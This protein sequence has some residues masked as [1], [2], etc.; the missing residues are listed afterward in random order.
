[1]TIKIIAIAIVT[2]FFTVLVHAQDTAEKEKLSCLFERPFIFGASISA[3]YGTL[4][5]GVNAI[6]TLKANEYISS[7]FAAKPLGSNPD[8]VTRLARTY[9]PNPQIT[10]ISEIINIMEHSSIGA[11]QFIS[12]ANDSAKEPNLAKSSVIVSV[13]GLYW[14]TIYGDDCSTTDYAIQGTRAVI[15]Y[16]HNRGIP[17]LLG[18]VP[19]EDPSKVSVS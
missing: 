5:D 17:L 13:D 1:M 12:Y 14:P 18:N 10:N 3:G 19:F 7:S 6:A 8:P 2:S 15:R 16:A 9:H 4:S 11:D